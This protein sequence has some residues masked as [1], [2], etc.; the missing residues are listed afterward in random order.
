MLE[1]N[2]MTEDVASFFPIAIAFTAT[3][4]VNDIKVA[5]CMF[6]DGGTAVFSVESSLVSDVYQVV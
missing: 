4:L 1:F 3:G 6:L 5:G 2:V